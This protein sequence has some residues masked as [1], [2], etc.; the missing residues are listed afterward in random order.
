MLNTSRINQS[1]LLS[2]AMAIAVAIFLFT[3]DVTDINSS[4][5]EQLAE[6]RS[7]QAPT[8]L[9]S[10]YARRYDQQLT[11]RMLTLYGRTQPN[12]MVTV[13]AELPA[14]VVAVNDLRGKL[15]K[16]GQEIARLQEGS[17]QAQLKFAKVQLKQ[18]QQE[19]KSAQ[20]LFKKNHIAENILTLREVEVAQAESTLED[21][22]IKWENTRITTPVAGILNERHVELGDFIDTG[23]PVANILD[24][25][26]LIVAIDVPQV[27]IAAFAIGDKAKIRFIDGRTAEA[28]IRF[29]DRQANPSTRT[30]SVELALSNPD[31]SIPAGLSV[32]ADLLMEK[33]KAIEVTPAL[34]ALSDKGEP[35]LKWV[36][37]QNRV[38]FSPVDIVKSASNSL[39]LTGIPPEARIITRGQG[40]VRT[41]D[42]VNVE[43]NELVA[44]E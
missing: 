44:G 40:F 38:Q 9:P 36:D 30:F 42:Q 25:D 26:P 32:E 28:S 19:Y 29:I 3:A 6:V 13:S 24:L 23:K 37:A 43:N 1:W 17:L 33:V 18:A 12:R 20:A 41:G 35:G 5:H 21:L 11:H 8:P 15:L 27:D 4:E 7:K 34:M 39:W 14:R 16:P 22:H 2:L 31:M 10:V